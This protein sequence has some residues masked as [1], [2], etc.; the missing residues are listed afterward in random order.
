MTEHLD[1]RVVD[2]AQV[3]GYLDRFGPFDTECARSVIARLLEAGLPDDIHI[4]F[5]LDAIRD[6]GRQRGQQR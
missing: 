6:E 5:V 1:A 2:E 4:T 3:R